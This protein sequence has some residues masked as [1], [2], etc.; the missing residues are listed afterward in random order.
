MIIKLGKKDETLDCIGSICPEPIVNL[1]KKM[2][3]M[4]S[5]KILELL[6]DDKGALG[7]VPAWCRRTRNKL[8][9]TVKHDNY[10]SF[11]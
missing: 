3:T 7:D 11:L 2:K 8:L 5:G 6:A 4:E 10:W 9:E 1:A